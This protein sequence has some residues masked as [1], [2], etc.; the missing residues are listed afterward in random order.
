MAKIML[1][2]AQMHG[3]PWNV[4]D[5]SGSRIAL[6]GGDSNRDCETFGPAIAAEIV[7]ALNASYDAQ[8]DSELREAGIDM[9]KANERLKA[10]L[11]R[12]RPADPSAEIARLRADV[13]R[14]REALAPV[15]AEINNRWADVHD[16]SWSA[17]Y[18][19][20]FEMTVAEC[21]TLLNAVGQPCKP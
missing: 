19:C 21:R 13:E 7:A 18:H 2:V 5:A 11:D 4:L 10:L 1:P 16:E 12:Y 9:T 15:V 14:L 8:I 3:C 17:D 6:C 20:E